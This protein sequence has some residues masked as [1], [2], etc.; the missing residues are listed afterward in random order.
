[1]TS[2][3][4]LKGWM[5]PAPEGEDGTLLEAIPHSKT[6]GMRLISRKTD[7]AVLM[8][9]YDPKLIG[10][11]ETGVL[12]GGVITALLDTCCGTAVMMSH[13]KPSST[14]TLDLRINY[15]RPAT[16]ERAVYAHAHCYRATRTVGFVRAVAFHEDK[17]D[18]IATAS[19]AFILN[20][21]G[22]RLSGES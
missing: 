20:Y 9:P 12:H 5:T 1:M 16:P 18:P 7:E 17:D 6:L 15:M 19:A 10:D 11:P 13:K 21:K 22:K 2:D 3:D 14:A 4:N 8:I